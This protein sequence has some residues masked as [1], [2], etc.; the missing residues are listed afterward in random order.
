MKSIKSLGLILL[1]FAGLCAACEDSTEEPRNP[2]VAEA[3]DEQELVIN[4]AALLDGSESVNAARKPI[5]YKW[6][7]VRKPEGAEVA[8]SQ[9]NQVAVQFSANKVG[10]YVFKLTVTYLNWTA[11]DTVTLKVVAG[12]ASKIEAKA[13]EDKVVPVETLVQLDGSGS[14]NETGGEIQFAWTILEKPEGSIA[15]IQDPNLEVAKLQP[16]TAG[17]YLLKLTVKFQSSVSSDL[18]EITATPSNGG[19][20]DPILISED[21]LEARILEN[22]HMEEDQLFDYL[23]TKDVEVAA[24]L[25][26]K[27]GV[28]IAFEA[29]AKLTVSSS[30]I[31]V[32]DN[33][34]VDS[35][36]IFE[37]KKS[38]KG[39]WG[40]IL[41]ES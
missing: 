11:T 21:I 16:D 6:E 31:L 17:K 4:T 25:I 38:E 7:L 27:P 32:A 22:I 9:L 3:G 28:R 39:F 37:G 19:A 8:T 18:M 1:V 15:Q 26:V 33:K 40:G 41:I 14:V 2:L 12:E 35:P 5:S 36:I 23:V 20:K 34:I 30:G 29:G 10:D 24:S 13:G